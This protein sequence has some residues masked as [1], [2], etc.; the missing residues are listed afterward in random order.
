MSTKLDAPIWGLSW[1]EGQGMRFQS[2]LEEILC[3]GGKVSHQVT[4]VPKLALPLIT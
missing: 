1:T 3:A 2:C 4:C